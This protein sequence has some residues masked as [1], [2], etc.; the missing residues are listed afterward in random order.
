MEKI[1]YGRVKVFKVSNPKDVEFQSVS[2]DMPLDLAYRTAANLNSAGWGKFYAYVETRLIGVFKSLPINPR[3]YKDGSKVEYPI[4]DNPE[5]GKNP[6]IVFYT[7]AIEGAKEGAPVDCMVDEWHGKPILGKWI[8][9]DTKPISGD[10][11]DYT[12]LQ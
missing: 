7:G 6:N 1:G 11:S 8:E 2:H 5:A 12:P 4:F 3:V 9:C 10:D